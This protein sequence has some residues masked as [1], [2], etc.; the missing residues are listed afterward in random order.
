[1]GEYREKIGAIDASTPLVNEAGYGGIDTYSTDEK[2]LQTC[3]KTA[4]DTDTLASR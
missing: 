2:A 1:M 3:L 4:A